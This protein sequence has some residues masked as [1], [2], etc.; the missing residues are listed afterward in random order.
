MVFDSF[1]CESLRIVCMVVKSD[2]HCYTEFLENGD[3]VCGG[4]DTI[5]GYL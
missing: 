2:H 1:F 5:L 3:I 4:E